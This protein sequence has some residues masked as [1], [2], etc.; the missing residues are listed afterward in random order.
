MIEQGT[1]I[2]LF[3][4]IGG[5]ALAA[6]WTGF[7]TVAFCECEPYAQRVLAKNF[8]GVVADTDCQRCGKAR[9][10]EGGSGSCRCGTPT[11]YPDVRTFPGERYAGATLLTGGFHCQPFSLAGQRA[12]KADERFIWPAMVAVVEVVRPAW[13]IGETVPGI[14]TMEL[15]RCAAD[16]ETQ[17]YAVWPVIVPACAVG[18]FHRRDRVWIVAHREKQGLEGADA[19]RPTRAKGRASECRCD[20]ADAKGCGGGS[21]LCEVGPEQDRNQSTDGGGTLADSESREGY[22]RGAGGVAEAQ[23]CWEGG[24]TAAHAGCEDVPD[25]GRRGGQGPG[26]VECGEPDA[27]WWEPEPD[28]GRVATGI[29][30]RV[31]RLRGL[32][33]AIVPQVAAELMRMICTANNRLSS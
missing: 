24:N 23:G 5:F 6:R 17:G 7:R 9:R 15:D 22:G 33:N 18:A 11:I 21:G 32:G 2:D 27:A 31:D 26:R 19:T 10:A 29:P 1:H 25:A 4:G 13:I 12:G 8:A 20:V 30:A 3:S 28:V 14:V 16:L